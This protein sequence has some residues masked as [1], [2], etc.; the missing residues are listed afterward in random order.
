MDRTERIRESEAKACIVT[1]AND[2]H[3]TTAKINASLPLTRERIYA[4]RTL[5]CGISGCSCT[6][7]DL[8]ARGP[9]EA[10]DTYHA[11]SDA[12]RFVY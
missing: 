11:L 5:L 2:F 9:Q 10:P 4:C 6:P 1:L 12:A 7:C 3:N 8:G